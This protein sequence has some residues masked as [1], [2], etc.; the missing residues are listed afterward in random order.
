MNI[1]NLPRLLYGDSN[2]YL[3]DQSYVA[4]RF[5]RERIFELNRDI[6]D[7]RSTPWCLNSHIDYYDCFAMED[8]DNSG[9]PF[10]GLATVMS[11]VSKPVRHV[12]HKT[13]NYMGVLVDEMHS[14]PA[15]KL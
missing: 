13:S 3:Q 8:V 12:P 7:E 6:R 4:D 14:F 15:M 5:Y 11:D 9:E 1:Y 2:I 10:Y